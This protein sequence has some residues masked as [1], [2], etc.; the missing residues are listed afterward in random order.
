M[1]IRNAR[2]TY[3]PKPR[4]GPRAEGEMCRSALGCLKRVVLTSPDSGDSGIP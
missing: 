3:A 1:S 2:N 4:G